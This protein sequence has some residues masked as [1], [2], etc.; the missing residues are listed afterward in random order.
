MT[1]KFHDVIA[2]AMAT[3][4]GAADAQQAGIATTASLLELAATDYERG[5]WREAFAAF[6]VLADR[7]EAEPARIAVLMWRLGPALY[8]TE[9]SASPEQLQ[10]WAQLAAAPKLTGCIASTTHGP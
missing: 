2:L 8:R 7:C 6:S 4:A 9:F 10:R 3:I 1:C 5:H